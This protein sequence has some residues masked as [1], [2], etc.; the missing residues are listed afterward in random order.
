MLAG[1][2][3]GQPLEAEKVPANVRDAFQSKFPGV[4]KVEWKLKSDKS[5]EVE[6]KLKDVEVAAKFSN[7]GKWL[8]TET[9]IEQSALPKA[10]LDTIAKE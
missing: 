7:K 10:V 9:A 8:E 4:E 5:Y 2:A 1:G 6:F 3:V